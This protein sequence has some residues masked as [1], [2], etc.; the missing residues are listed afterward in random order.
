MS[1]LKYESM[2]LPPSPFVRRFADNLPRDSALDVLDAG[3]CMG[4]NAIHIAKLGHNVIG[5]NLLIDELQVAQKDA[6]GSV[7]FVAAD[8][9][10]L[11]FQKKFDV[12]LMNEVLHM[13]PKYEARLA[14]HSLASVTRPGGF[15][16][17]S[18]YIGDRPQALQ[19]FELRDLY[20]GPQWEIQ[21]YY[22]DEPNVEDSQ[23]G[24][25]TLATIVAVKN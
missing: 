20:S 7:M 3:C 21:S 19:P 11:P 23:A 25:T 18:G 24:L 13:L 14:V 5:L 15:H 2:A 6:G 12:V 4:R 22:E 10:R 16:A 1:I 17:V 8:I 9:R